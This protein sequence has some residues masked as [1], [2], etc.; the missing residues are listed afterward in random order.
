[1]SAPGKIK[2]QCGCCGSCNCPAGTPCAYCG[3]CTPNSYRVVVSGSLCEGIDV[4]VPY[5]SC[6]YEY[7]QTP[8]SVTVLIQAET[9]GITIE[10]LAGTVTGSIPNAG[11]KNSLTIPLDGGGTASLTACCSA[12]PDGCLDNYTLEFDWAYSQT[13]PAVEGC[14]AVNLS[15][16][17][18]VSVTIS[19]P[20]CLESWSGTYTGIGVSMISGGA[21][22]VLGFWN[23]F[24]GY[25]PCCSS[26]GA[27]IPPNES[28]SCPS[29]TYQDQ[30]INC[31]GDCDIYC[32]GTP[33]HF[34]ESFSMT[35]I[36]VH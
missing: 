24:A 19:R 13:A 28:Q 10:C 5:T 25:T 26:T 32:P 30:I 16:S 9:I 14:A 35:N 15:G 21:I 3:A 23:Y 29:F 18:H 33:Q 11:C 2:N 7:N 17:G 20:S 4:C 31:E 12:C 36:K 6:A 8:V 27:T 22:S 34:T 1:M